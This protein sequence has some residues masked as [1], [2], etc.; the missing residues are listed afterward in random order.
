MVS[1]APPPPTSPHLDDF[2]EMLWGTS[3]V[4]LKFCYEIYIRNGCNLMYFGSSCIYMN[5]YVDL[6]NQKDKFCFR[7]VSS[8]SLKFIL[9][10]RQKFAS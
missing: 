8:I 10:S 2:K 1:T 5:L 7:N 9:F 4:G 6:F 3:E